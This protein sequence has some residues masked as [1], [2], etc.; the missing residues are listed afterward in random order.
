MEVRGTLRCSYHR[1]AIVV[2]TGA[3]QEPLLTSTCHT[4]IVIAVVPCLRASRACVRR[5]FDPQSHP[6]LTMEEVSRHKS[7]DDAWTVINGKV[8]DVTK[9]I[10]RE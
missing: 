3:C 1:G 9:F 6:Q 4:H 8:Y 5:A 2:D 7:E 10:E